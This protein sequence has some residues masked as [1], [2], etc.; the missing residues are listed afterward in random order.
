MAKRDHE[1]SRFHG[2]TYDGVWAMAMA[3]QAVG[4]RLNK[5]NHESRT[6]TTVQD[7]R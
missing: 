5:R 4:H 1:Y 2:Y 7:F 6:N 3:I